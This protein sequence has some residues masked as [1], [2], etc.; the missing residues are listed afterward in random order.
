MATTAAGAAAAA[1]ATAVSLQNAAVDGGGFPSPVKRSRVKNC[2]V[3]EEK[4]RTTRCICCRKGLLLT[5]KSDGWT[6]EGQE[7]DCGTSG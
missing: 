3:R 7:E 1:A 4:E 5:C 2:G 6:E